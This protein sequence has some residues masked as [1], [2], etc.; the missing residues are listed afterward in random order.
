MN[1]KI[2]EIEILMA[3]L[4]DIPTLQIQQL[5]LRSCVGIP[6]ILHI[7]R[8]VDPLLIPNIVNRF[9][10]LIYEAL[11]NITVY[12]P[13]KWSRTL[14]S[15]P[16]RM[17]GFGFPEVRQFAAPAYLGSLIQSH[18][19]QTRLLK[20]EFFE[21]EHR[22]EQ[23]VQSWIES[24]IPDSNAA[25]V[26]LKLS[27]PNAKPQSILTNLVYEHSLREIEVSTQ[28]NIALLNARKVPR[29]SLWLNAIPAMPDLRINNTQFR[30]V[31]RYFAGISQYSAM[32]PCSVC[33]RAGAMSGV[34]GDHEL[35]CTGGKR[36]VKRHDAV[37]NALGKEARDA[38]FDV[39]I[40]EV[41]LIA[42]TEE[43]PADVLISN[44]EYGMDFCID[45]TVINPLAEAYFNN[46]VNDPLHAVMAAEERKMV[47]YV[48][49]CRLEILDAY[50]LG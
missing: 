40:E 24:T 41:G 15:L 45:V 16:I 38:G 20:Q 23:K 8:V 25:E 19:L 46:S 18:G 29:S 3:R 28:R 33:S 31:F 48:D 1:R 26:I 39:K 14:M 43:R 11:T 34:E 37:R 49:A 21:D 6:K 42:N 17:G 27:L 12:A 7:L 5:I 30:H 47:Q 2:D 22:A 44:W 32:R 13:S 50:R 9:D 4:R 35:S 36:L 10:R